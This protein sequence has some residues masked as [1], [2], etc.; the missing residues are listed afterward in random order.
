MINSN[1]RQRHVVREM[2]SGAAVVGIQNSGVSEELMSLISPL[3]YSDPGA[4][5]PREG[6]FGK[7]EEINNST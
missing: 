2:G 4:V 6:R 3:P 5:V 1:L 7:G